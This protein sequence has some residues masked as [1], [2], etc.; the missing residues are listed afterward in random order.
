[1][2]SGCIIMSV[3]ASAEKNSEQSDR[4]PNGRS[5]MQYVIYEFVVTVFVDRRDPK[6][7]KKPAPSVECVLPA[8]DRKDHAG[9]VGREISFGLGSR[10]SRLRM[11][12]VA[13]AGGG[14]SW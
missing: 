3:V 2:I 8:R 13:L 1:M 11:V 7:E 10:R 5:R 6:R 12:E 14:W 4:N 9:E